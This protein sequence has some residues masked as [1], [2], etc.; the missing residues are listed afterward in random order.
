MKMFFRIIVLVLVSSSL[1]SQTII[2][3]DNPSYQGDTNA[4]LD[5]Y[6][7]SKGFLPPRLTTAQR[8]TIAASA[9][10]GLLIFNTDVSKLQMR[11]LNTVVDTISQTLTDTY[12]NADSSLSQQFV[13]VVPGSVEQVSLWL[14][15]VT[16]GT[17]SVKITDG[18]TPGSGTVLASSSV[19]ITS[20]N[21][22]YD[23]SFSIPPQVSAGVM[24]LLHVSDNGLSGTLTGLSSWGDPYPEGMSFWDNS[25]QT[26]V[27]LKFQVLIRTTN[28]ATLI[29]QLNT[30]TQTGASNTISQQ[31]VPPNDGTIA[32]A[33][34]WL[35][36]TTPG[37]VS[38]Q[39]LQGSTPAT[40]TVIAS[41]NVTITST[42]AKYSVVFS[43]LP[44]VTS[45]STYLIHVTDNGAAGGFAWQASWGNLYTPGISYWDN[46]PQT[47][48][49]M[50]FEVL[51]LTQLNQWI[52]LN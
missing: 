46:N 47:L 32:K 22:Q 41:E 29:S 33:T 25:Q 40:G 28:Q 24:Y 9:T 10:D 6:S 15:H 35:M 4:M 18:T 37:A 11:L 3:S 19:A 38:V 8:N 31:I 21:Q 44:S 16:P 49:D 5:V 13:P 45:G 39:V 20:T 14:Q 36:H 50:K 7:T 2:I 17:V 12:T 42:F 1:S 26:S 52:D 34:L 43:S 27:D 51:L 23:V 30:D 48:V